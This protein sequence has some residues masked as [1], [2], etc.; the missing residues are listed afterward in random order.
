[1][2]YCFAVPGVTA[3][4][5]PGTFWVAA[6]GA[7]RAFG[8]NK[9]KIFAKSFVSLKKVSTFAVPFDENGIFYGLL[10]PKVL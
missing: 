5:T 8:T 6:D 2:S 9:S 4:I 10:E 1:M 7:L 3:E